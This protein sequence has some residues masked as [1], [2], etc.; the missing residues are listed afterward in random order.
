VVAE[1]RQGGVVSFS[2][3]SHRCHRRGR[4]GWTLQ[5]AR[6][7]CAPWTCGNVVRLDSTGCIRRRE[8]H[9]GSDGSGS[10]FLRAH[11]ALR[12]FAS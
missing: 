1:H 5:D 3:M 12:P 6:D 8:L 7:D 9:Y 4:T 10:E 2:A 11:H